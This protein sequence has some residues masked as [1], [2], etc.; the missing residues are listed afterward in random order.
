ML[1]HL[2]FVFVVTKLINMPLQLK[3]HIIMDNLKEIHS[4]EIGLAQW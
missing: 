1:R 3:N 4:A 2:D